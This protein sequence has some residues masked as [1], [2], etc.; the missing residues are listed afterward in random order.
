MFTLT[1]NFDATGRTGV[2]ILSS[3]N[4]WTYQ[5]PPTEKI[6][7]ADFKTRDMDDYR[8]NGN[9]LSAS[10]LCLYEMDTSN[11]SSEPPVELFLSKHYGVPYQLQQGDLKVVIKN[12]KKN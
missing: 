7:Y 3:E 6:I 10:H 9:Q 8:L 11:I 4:E 2:V 5:A 12:L 1:K